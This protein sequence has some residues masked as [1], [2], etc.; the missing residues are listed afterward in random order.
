MD[1]DWRPLFVFD[2]NKSNINGYRY[3]VIF[4]YLFID[5]KELKRMKKELTCTVS[6]VTPH[7]TAVSVKGN[8]YPV[9]NQ[10]KSLGL[11]WNTSRKAWEIEGTPREVA[12]AIANL[13]MMGVKMTYQDKPVTAMPNSYKMDM[14]Y[15][16]SKVSHFYAVLAVN[17]N[18]EGYAEAVE[19][20][21]FFK[22]THP[23]YIA[24]YCDY[25]GDKISTDREAAAYMLALWAAIDDDRCP[26]VKRME[27]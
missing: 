1:A 16:A 10:I 4:I 24:A 11:D 21:D 22:S 6:T 2:C 20:F 19:A 14:V 23:E 8:T 13:E 26:W 7:L 25:T 12:K 3:G 18:A 5:R 15:F 17:D 27:G 9:H